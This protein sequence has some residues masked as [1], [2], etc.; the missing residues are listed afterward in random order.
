MN[1]LERASPEDECAW[2]A[3]DTRSPSPELWFGRA[4]HYMFAEHA[5]VLA[6]SRLDPS[7]VRRAIADALRASWVFPDD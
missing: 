1:E 4:D 2:R 3:Q 5:P 7:L 6:E